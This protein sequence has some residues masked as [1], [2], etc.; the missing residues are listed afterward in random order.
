MS[1]ATCMRLHK[2][3]KTRR[4]GHRP[5]QSLRTDRHCC[6]TTRSIPFQLPKYHIYTA[7]KDRPDVKEIGE[8]YE[9]IDLEYEKSTEEKVRQRRNKLKQRGGNKRLVQI[10][11][12]IL[13]ACDDLRPLKEEGKLVSLNSNNPGEKIL[14]VPWAYLFGLHCRLQ[15]RKETL[16]KRELKNPRFR[17]PELQIPI[18]VADVRIHQVLDSVIPEEGQEY[19]EKKR[20]DVFGDRLLDVL[21]VLYEKR[22]YDPE[23]GWGYLYTIATNAETPSKINPKKQLSDRQLMVYKL[24]DEVVDYFLRSRGYQ[25]PSSNL[26]RVTVDAV[27]WAGYRIGGKNFRFSSSKPDEKDGVDKALSRL[28]SDRD[29]LSKCIDDAVENGS[30]EGIEYAHRSRTFL[31][32]LLLFDGR[33][34]TSGTERLEASSSSPSVHEDMR[35]D[36]KLLRRYLVKNKD[37]TNFDKFFTIFVM[38]SISGFK[39]LQVEKAV[40]DMGKFS[41]INRENLDRDEGE[42]KN[43]DEGETTWS[44]TMDNSFSPPEPRYPEISHLT[45]ERVEVVFADMAA[46]DNNLRQWFNNRRNNMEDDVRSDLKVLGR[47]L[48]KDAP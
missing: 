41:D 27:K 21:E 1:P 43:L 3:T 28:T 2:Q 30:P 31:K 23:K 10:C 15:D 17:K 12:R 42:D 32:P 19:N 44:V 29:F 38:R 8:I 36:V 25:P 37:T 7:M 6:K 33:I 14:W 46:N 35:R 13:R 9:E 20:E 18:A 16:P 39:Y 22:E 48:F 11:D 40:N 34:G 24:Y 47:Y 45:A 5:G 4:P 26:D